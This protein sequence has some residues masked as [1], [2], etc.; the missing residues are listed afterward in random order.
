MAYKNRRNSSV[1]ASVAWRLYITLFK[2]SKGGH[3]GKE[4]NWREF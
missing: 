2:G 3:Y 4:N 1:Y